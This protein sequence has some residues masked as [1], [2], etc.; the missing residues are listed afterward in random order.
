MASRKVS[1][2]KFVGTV[3]LGLL[4]VSLSIVTS[5]IASNDSSPLREPH[6]TLTHY[7]RW[8]KV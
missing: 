1:V 3:S 7:E 6:Q 8:T 2:L 4:T 5:H